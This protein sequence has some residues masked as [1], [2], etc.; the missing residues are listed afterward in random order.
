WYGP[1]PR[2]K[3]A[4]YFVVF[5]GTGFVIDDAGHLVTNNHVVHPGAPW[6]GTPELTVE[7]PADFNPHP[8]SFRDKAEQEA[9]SHI[10]IRNGRCF[11]VNPP[12]VGSDALADLAVVQIPAGLLKPLEF[13]DPKSVQVG[14]DVLAVG[15]AH[16]LIGAPTV[17]KGIVSAVG[18]SFSE[19][20]VE[21]GDLIQ[22]DCAINHGNSGGPLLNMAG[23]VVGVNTYTMAESNDAQTQGMYLARS[24]RTAALYVHDIIEDGSVVRGNLGV[25]LTTVNVAAARNRNIPEGVLITDVEKGSAAAAAGIHS[26][27]MI[28][29]VGGREVHSIGDFNDALALVKPGEKVEV[30]HLD[31]D[32][33]R[34]AL[35]QVLEAIFSGKPIDAT[36]G[37]DGSGAKTAIVVMK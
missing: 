33:D 31:V 6:K 3:N 4:D 36:D 30:E 27:E 35:G 13:A 21:A 17:T 22:T 23:E 9:Y 8:A 28:L 20:G 32:A 7:L 26:G 24:S 18:R 12:I 1:I 10:V 34:R 5:T 25:N 19:N 29:R 16:G 14:Q 2:H 15:F 11:L 37:G